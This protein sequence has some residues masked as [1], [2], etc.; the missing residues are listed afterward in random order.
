MSL[1]VAPGRRPPVSGALAVPSRGFRCTEGLRVPAERVRVY[2][3]GLPACFVARS[4]LPRHVLVTASTNFEKGVMSDKFRP[5]FRNGF[6]NS[7]DANPPTPPPYP[8][9]P[10]MTA[11]PR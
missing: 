2:L 1:P 4:E 7:G 8:T 11:A 3:G 6:G 9:R 5:R 10:A